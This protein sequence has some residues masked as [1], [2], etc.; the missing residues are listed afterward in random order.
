V[1]KDTLQNLIAL[2][3][4]LDIN[5]DI[6]LQQ[7]GWQV[8]LFDLLL[9]ANQRDSSSSPS[10]S[11]SSSLSS[12]SSSFSSS[13]SLSNQQEGQE[14]CNLEQ[15]LIYDFFDKMHLYSVLFT[16]KGAHILQQS[17]CVL[18]ARSSSIDASVL[19]LTTIYSLLAKLFPS[20][21][22]EQ[23]S[24]ARDY[25]PDSEKIKRLCFALV[26]L[27]HH[28][29][30]CLLDRL[31][32]YKD[33]TSE[34]HDLAAVWPITDLLIEIHHWACTNY[35]EAAPVSERGVL[36]YLMALISRIRLISSSFVAEQLFSSLLTGN[37]CVV[38][39]CVVL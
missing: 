21:Q 22:K 10:P 20:I 8:W 17:F 11:S 30:E 29:E 32:Q 4:Q 26:D 37:V 16:S 24:H 28:V 15:D 2:F 9:T 34:S 33:D 6:L 13:S 5:K 38:L 19:P 27:S 25:S 3:S 36:P 35:P 18:L 39:C 1:F 12:S 14:N 31:G 23:E 7:F